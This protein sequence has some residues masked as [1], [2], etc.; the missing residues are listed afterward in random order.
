MS[1]QNAEI[2]QE[3]S[4]DE[5][6]VEEIDGIPCVSS[7][8]VAKHFAGKDHKKVLRTIRDVSS[9]CPKSFAG[10]NFGP[11]EYLDQNEQK[12]P[13]FYL[14]EKGFSLVVMGFTGAEAIAWKIRYIER[15]HALREG[16][17]QS[18]DM[19]QGVASDIVK[20]FKEIA[21]RIDENGRCLGN[22]IA[23][24]EQLGTQTI[25][26]LNDHGAT[27]DDHGNRLARLENNYETLDGRLRKK[28]T[29]T[30]KR[31]HRAI[32]AR[33]FHGRCPCC[34]STII[35]DP[36][37]KQTVS[38]FEYDHYH[39]AARASFEETWAICEKCHDDITFNRVVRNSDAI[40]PS[41]E[42]YQ[43]KARNYANFKWEKRQK[44]PSSIQLPIVFNSLPAKID[45]PKAPLAVAEAKEIINSTVMKLYHDGVPR[46][47]I[48]KA[49]NRTP[50]RISQIVRA[51][52]G[53]FKKEAA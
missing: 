28:I 32:V 7:L 38:P 39:S 45:E 5:I 41:F 34:N 36:E 18:V 11:G 3:I 2:T 37:T 25:E 27:L 43:S 1:L 15:F 8:M 29:D 50:A 16:F 10:A 21:S 12:R 40:R 46:D 52:G 4:L 22:Q 30:V 24:I 6:V 51:H 17:R 47:D 13:M 49:V 31:K 20:A 26:I 33:V 35:I 48:A 19:N 9:K 53:S 14:T 23:K 44:K 42:N